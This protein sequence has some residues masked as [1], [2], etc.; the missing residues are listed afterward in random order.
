MMNDYTKFGDLLL[1]YLGHNRMSRQQLSNELGVSVPT[2][3]KWINGRSDRPGSEGKVICIADCLRVD[4]EKCVRL[5]QAA[6]YNLTEQ[7]REETFDE[8][9]CRELEW[10]YEQLKCI[11]NKSELS[12]DEQQELPFMERAIAWLEDSD[13]VELAA[14]S[15][16]TLDAQRLAALEVKAQELQGLDQRGLN[17]AAPLSDLEVGKAELP[18]VV[19]S[20]STVRPDEQQSRELEDIARMQQD[21]STIVKQE[22]SNEQNNENSSLATS[23]VSHPQIQV[24]YRRSIR[25]VDIRCDEKIVG[26]PKKDQP[27]SFTVEPGIHFLQATHSASIRDFDRNRVG[28]NPI[29]IGRV[30]YNRDWHEEKGKSAKEAY[31]FKKGKIYIFECGIGLRLARVV[32]ELLIKVGIKT[33][34][35]FN[36]YLKLIRVTDQS[37][38][39][40]Q[41]QK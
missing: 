35:K 4:R 7:Q 12:F 29:A 8:Y 38:L 33:V 22:V 39:Q 34:S 16:A 14:A 15:S 9:A 2:I 13:V 24:I 28:F 19:S 10:Q 30:V 26:M 17:Q 31:D 41:S 1:Q 18:A 11:V 23:A 37:E 40:N 21:D 5:L 6:E 3:S 32:D 27:L 20:L 25:Y 36:V